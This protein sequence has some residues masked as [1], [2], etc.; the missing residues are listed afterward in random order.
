MLKLRKWLKIPGPKDIG[1]S[2]SNYALPSRE[3]GFYNDGDYCWEDYE[4]DIKIMF[5]IRFFIAYTLVNFIKYKLWFP[6]KNPIKHLHYWLT[7]HIIPKR[8][9]HM[10]DLRQ[11]GGYQYGWHDVPEKMLYAMFNLL[12]EY[13]EEE[14]Y[15]LT[16]DYTRDEIESDPA[17]KIQQNY[18]DEARIIHKWWTIDRKLELKEHYRLLDIWHKLHQSKTGDIAGARKALNDDEAIFEAKTDNMIARLM[19]IRRGLWT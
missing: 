4:T 14:P 1:K 9:F 6:I 16:K 18:L 19:K 15:D 11:P 8:R 17:M 5:P 7:S 3:L 12:K 10:L 2:D 13:L